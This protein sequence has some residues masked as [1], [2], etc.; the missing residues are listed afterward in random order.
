MAEKAQGQPKPPTYSWFDQIP[1][2][3]QGSWLT[4]RQ[5]AE[6]GLRPGGPIVAQVVWGRGRK[7]KFANL[8]DKAEAKPKKE[9]TVAQLAALE[10]AQLKRRTCPGCGVDQGFVLPWRWVPEEHC[11]VCEAR[12]IAHDRA[13]AIRLA[14]EALAAPETI[15]VDTET[16]GLDGYLVEIAVIDT[17]GAVL[18]N[19]RINPQAPIE[20]GAQRI[21]GISEAD[22][23][24]APTF[25]QI[26]DDLARAC[27][28]RRIWTYNAAFDLGIIANEV[29]RHS[30]ATA[31]A[32][33]FK[34]DPDGEA[35]A[36]QHAGKQ[37]CRW[38]SRA[39]RQWRCLMR[40]YGEFVGEWSSYH[41]DYRFQRLPGG[42]H[43]AL[44]DA[45]A[46]LAVLRRMAEAEI[47]T[48]EQEL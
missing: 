8:Y 47:E 25:A 14:R 44:G 18:L 9:A 34:D 27:E 15:I 37:W 4:R 29:Y 28:G 42:D 43:T 10:Q 1:Q 2:E 36:R 12:Q 41:G 17:T 7:E 13:E 31:L 5:L 16:T 23:A 39:G 20:E 21:H 24:D 30:E 6:L 19:T 48:A 11:V 46:A 40:L 38:R 33:R 35:K 45:R 32:G 26:K 3:H 22:L